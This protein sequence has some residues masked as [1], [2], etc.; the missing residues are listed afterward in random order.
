MDSMVSWIYR[1][2]DALSRGIVGE[3]VQGCWS[4]AG[5]PS[6]QGTLPLSFVPSPSSSGLWPHLTVQGTDL[7]LVGR[8]QEEAAHLP[9]EWLFYLHIDIIARSLLLV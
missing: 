4:S 9:L 1:W 8:G 2:K 7:L 5:H 6:P 3:E